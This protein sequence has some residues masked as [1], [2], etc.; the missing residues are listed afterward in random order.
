MQNVS[1]QFSVNFGSLFR[2]R[3]GPLPNFFVV[4]I[5]GKLLSMGEGGPLGP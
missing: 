3:L 4:D 2:R 1:V 5:F